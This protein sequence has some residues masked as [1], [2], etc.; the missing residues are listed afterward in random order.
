PGHVL[1]GLASEFLDTPVVALD[2]GGESLRGLLKAAAAAYAAGA[3]V[4][5]AA[6]FADR[7][8]KPFR[9]DWQPRFFANPCEQAPLVEFLSAFEP[10]RD[11]SATRHESSEHH[12]EVNLDA[13][14]RAGI[15]ASS[16]LELVRHLVA[17]RAELPLAAVKDTDRLLGDLHL[18][19]IA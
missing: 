10:P 18:N 4:N 11:E 9:L 5:H 8:T 6:L 13:S 3:P 15:A 17:A 1:G 14:G 2:A 16:S 19:S 7:I 12:I